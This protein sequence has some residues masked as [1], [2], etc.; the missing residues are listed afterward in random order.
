MAQMGE[1]LDLFAEDE[2]PGRSRVLEHPKNL[3]EV[4]VGDARQVLGGFPDGLS[5]AS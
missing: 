5:S 3:C 4:I 1:V 2:L